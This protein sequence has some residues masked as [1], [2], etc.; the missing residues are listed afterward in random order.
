MNLEEILEEKKSVPEA[1]PVPF[2][3]IVSH[4]VDF[5]EDSNYEHYFDYPIS[6]RYHYCKA[7]LNDE[8]DLRLHQGD[9]HGGRKSNVA[10]S[11]LICAVKKLRGAAMKRRSFVVP[12]GFKKHLQV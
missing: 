10:W 3:Q 8:A 12:N 9:S 6:C 5:K 2:T 7:I 4:G 1:Q 11:C